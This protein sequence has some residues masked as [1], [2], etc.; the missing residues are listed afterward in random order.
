MARDDLHFRLRIPE[1]LKLKVE[2]AAKDSHRSMTAEIIARLERSFS[3][4][5]E[6]NVYFRKS[7]V[8]LL[9]M[10]LSHDI[11]DREKLRET[12]GPKTHDDVERVLNFW[13]ETEQMLSDTNKPSSSEDKE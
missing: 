5:A 10:L 13:F 9:A 6:D 8:E 3:L 2:E 4:G 11:I 7:M 12:Y 1:D